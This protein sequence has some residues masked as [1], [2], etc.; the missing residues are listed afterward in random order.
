M[1][2]GASAFHNLYEIPYKNWRQLPLKSVPNNSRQN[3]DIPSYADYHGLVAESEDKMH[4][5]LN[6]NYKIAKIY[7]ME[8]S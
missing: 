5:P 6:N 1:W 2:P 7:D 3:L 8:I 4:L